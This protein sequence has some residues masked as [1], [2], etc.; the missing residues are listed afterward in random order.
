MASKHLKKTDTAPKGAHQAPE[1]SP[2]PAAAGGGL[3]GFWKTA[4]SRDPFQVPDTEEQ[5]AALPEEPEGPAPKKAKRSGKKAAGESASGEKAPKEKKAKDKT[6]REKTAKETSPKE[7]AKK[8]RAPKE[9]SSG[10]KTA[11]KK[12]ARETAPAQEQTPDRAAAGGR[13]AT[14]GE[15]ARKKPVAF[16]RERDRDDGG[17]SQ[18]DAVGALIAL[19]AA[20]VLFAA[21]LVIWLYRDS[22]S[23]DN[24]ILSADTAA[25]ATDEYVFDAGSGQAFAAAGSGLAVANAAGLELLDGDGTPVTSMLMQMENPAAAG[26]DSFAVFYDL[27][28]TRLAVAWFD[29]TVQELDVPGAI[30]SATVSDTGYIAL[31]TEYRGYRALVTVY[32]PSLE[33]VYEWYSSSAW[34]ISACVSPDGRQLA[35]LSYTASGSEVR[36]FDLSRNGVQAEAAFSVENT[37]LLDLHW[38]SSSRLCTLSSEQMFFFGSDGQWQNTYSFAG[39]YLVGY[40]FDGGNCAALALS[41]YRAGT[42][43]T[44]VSLDPT[45]NVL[46]TA[47]MNSGIVCLT[48]SDLEILILSADGATLYNSSLMEK[49]RLNGLPGFKYAMLRSR[50]EALLIASNYAEV[51]KF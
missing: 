46:G 1:E 27:G 38:F 29:G 44:L 16:R 2:D 15:T 23:P 9:K 3:K 34:V 24:M 39:Q 43:A 6:A 8:E 51:Y 37:I 36:F 47:E 31:T 11:R 20:V 5:Y 18:R 13:H 35:V 25:V 14:D 40:S 41:P 17:I 45:G 22:F 49:G 26:C 4:R 19:V 33:V 48:A 30:L 12:T 32:D 42:T 10:E 21:T 28:G 50:G 7:T